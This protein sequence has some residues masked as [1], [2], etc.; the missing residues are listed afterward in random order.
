MR[1]T[2]VKTTVVRVPLKTAAKWSGGTRETAPA[3]LVEIETDEGLVGLGEGVGPTIPTLHT[4]LRD[5][6]R[7]MLLGVDPM[8]TEWIVHRLEELAINWAG[9]GA[10]GIAAVEMALLDLKGKALNTP[11]ANLLGGVYRSEIDYQGYLFIAEP[12]VNAVEAAAYARD[13]FRTLKVKVGR[14]ID[15]DARRLKAIREAVGWEIRIR[16]DANMNWSPSTAIRAIRAMEPYH[17]EFVEQ[18]VPFYDV[19]GMAQVAR[20]VDVPIAAD[21]GCTSMRDALALIRHKACEVFVI[22][23]SEAGGLMKAREIVA[24]ANTE[25]IACVLGTWAEL[26]IGTAAGAHL[27]ASSRNFTMASDTHYPLQDGDIIAPMLA[28]RNGRLALPQGPGLGVTLDRAAVERFARQEAR[29]TVFY[30]RDNPDF[31]PRIGQILY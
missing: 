6:F 20:A 19:E 26:G 3:I 2:D 1:I 11:V 7:P 25:G 16:I 27:I 31:I 24:L 9:V 23:V 10:H 18:P 17:L 4:V 28:I 30:D 12:D 29:E 21:E 5:E 8:R 15:F 22:Y 14:E 13:G